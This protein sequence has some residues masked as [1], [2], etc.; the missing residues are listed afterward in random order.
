VSRARA[1]VTAAL[2][3]MLAVPGAAAGQPAPAAEDEEFVDEARPAPVYVAELRAPRRAV[4]GLDF[5]LGVLDAVCGGCYAEGGLS[6]DLFAGVQL[7]PRVALLADAWAL[8]HLVAGDDNQSGV[9]ALVI[10]SVGARVWVVPRLWLQA[11]AGAAWLVT[12]GAPA[13]GD[14]ADVGPGAMVA[15]GGE[16]G[17]QRWSG[18]DLSLRMGGTRLAAGDEGDDVLVYSI[19]AVVGFHW[20]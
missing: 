16:L 8:S 10:A 14:D 5:G 6:L 15:I 2:A 12:S 17:H 13:G 9:A 4:F 3:A 11:G 20:N 18:I 7:A 19:A 1:R